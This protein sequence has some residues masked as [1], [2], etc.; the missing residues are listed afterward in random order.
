VR[1][2]DLN[3]SILALRY[4]IG[5]LHQGTPLLRVDTRCRHT[6]EMFAGGYVM[7]ERKD[8]QTGHVRPA[9]GEE[10]PKK[11][12]FYDHFADACRY[13]L[14]G[15]ANPLPSAGRVVAFQPRVAV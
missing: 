6:I 1:K 4:L 8:E 10:K 15:T 12:G 3:R 5:R 9:H 11:D 2:L 13:M 7:D 14:A